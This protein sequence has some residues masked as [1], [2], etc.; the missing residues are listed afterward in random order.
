MNGENGRPIVVDLDGTLVNSDMLVENL[1]LFLRLYPCR[2]FHVL[3]WL[4][5]G[6]A[7]LKRNLADAVL[8]EASALPYNQCLVTW[9][10][11]QR[12]QGR[13]LVLATASD[14]RIA[15]RVAAHV[16]LFDEVLGTNDVNLSSSAKR[17]VL[18]ERYGDKG[19]EYVGNSMADLV[20][21]ASA[22]LIHVANP[23]GGVLSKVRRLGGIANV[24]DERPSRLRSLCKE[25]RIHQWAKN[26]LIFVPLLASHRLLEWPLLCKGIIAF[27][28]FG[29]CAS[30]VY[31]LNDLFD[32][33]DDRRH[34]SKCHRPLA[35][36]SLSIVS[37]L[38][39]IPSL[40][41]GAI[42]LAVVALP[43]GF[44]MVLG[45]YY[46]LTLAYSIYL[47]RK[48]MLDVIT[49][50]SL[51]TIRVIA[52]AQAVAV[53]TTVWM[54]AFC[55]FLFL[56]LAFIKRYTELRDTLSQRRNVKLAG[57]GYLPAD[58][59]LLAS[60]GG[61]SGYLS[62]LV[63]ALYINDVAT[64]MLY[65]SPQWMWGACLL[66]LYWL[67]RTWII[68]H[69]GLMHDDPIVF[70]LR[71]KVSYL[72]AFLFVLVFLLAKLI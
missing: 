27:I 71:D 6:K 8:P 36:G 4:M 19:Y 35:A 54:L 44:V 29:A 26:A 37:A 58:F 67:S 23:G 45:A 47:K 32:L 52:G 20:V 12:A 65:R 39:L 18:V 31:L 17:D 46:L 56:S 38:L 11:T 33:P 59:A 22:S 34:P 63:L 55:I 53:A 15:E 70:A 2:V 3:A 21:W 41:F 50:A 61:A 42:V 28:A 10:K 5:R 25:L 68:A 60:L 7:C 64:S 49:L 30:S 1:F 69:R 66:L 14:Q 51:Y 62:V 24:F 57:R 9:L 48:V 16:G 43:P 40:F 13:H 72:T